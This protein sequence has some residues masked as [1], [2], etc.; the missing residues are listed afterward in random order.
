MDIMEMARASFPKTVEM[1]RY[2]HE[3]PEL[4]S[5][6]DGTIAYIKSQLDRMGVPYHEVPNGGLLGFID[7]DTPGKTLLMR[8]DIDALPIQEDERNLA[9]TRTCISK[10][11]GVCHACGHDAHTAML[12]SQAEILSANRDQFSGRIVLCFER[13][14]EGT[15]NVR[16]LLDYIERESGLEIDGCYATHVLWNL[17]TGKI[18]ANSGA[19]MAGGLGFEVRIIGK[20][21]HGSRPDL[22]NNPIDCFVAICNSLNSVRLRMINPFDLLTFSIGELHSGTKINVVP[23]DLVFSGTA[24][25]FKTEK[26]GMRFASVLKHIV[27]VEAESYGCD[28]EILHMPNPMYEVFNDPIC[29]GIAKMAITKHIGTH[30][31]AHAEPWMASETMNMY[32]RLYP[33]LIT[34]TGLRTPEK[35]SGANHHTPQF[36]IDEDCLPYGVAAGLAY[37]IEFLAYSQPI[38][39]KRRI[40]SLNDLIT[41]S[42]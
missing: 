32:L 13:G 30:A 2:L 33:G 29:A 20:S 16:Y 8:A 31:V 22:A 17:D 42:L 24:R 36:D 10:T 11:P 39:F 23:E 4:S 14:E 18:A 35:G 27:A 40:H 25:F 28:Y 12:L 41:R 34:F 9:R 1:R 19:V 26:V 37:A 15:G 3:H 5:Q 6:E 21:G 7:G 38:P